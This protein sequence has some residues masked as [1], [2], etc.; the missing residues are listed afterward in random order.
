MKTADD[1]SALQRIKDDL[2][3]KAG[4]D[5]VPS[6]Y[7][8]KAAEW[9]LELQKIIRVMSDYSLKAERQIKNLR[10]KVAAK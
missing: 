8:K 1:K 6:A 3:L 4:T 7:A 10:K 2:A 9:I 5:D